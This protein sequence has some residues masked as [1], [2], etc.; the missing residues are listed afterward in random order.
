L[1]GRPPAEKTVQMK[2][3]HPIQIAGQASAGRRD[4]THENTPLTRGD[5]IKEVTPDAA[6]RTD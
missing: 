3:T 6:H 2:R 1:S 5:D 4:D